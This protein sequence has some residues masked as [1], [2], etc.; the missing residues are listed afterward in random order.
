MSAVKGRLFWQFWSDKNFVLNTLFLLTLFYF[1]K[2]LLSAQSEQLLEL[3]AALSKDTLQLIWP[4]TPL[5]LL[6]PLLQS[7]P[8][9]LTMLFSVSLFESITSNLIFRKCNPVVEGCRLL[10]AYRWSARWRSY[11]KTGRHCQSSLWFW[12]WGRRW[13][14]KSK[15]V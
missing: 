15:L 7:T 13:G 8:K 1:Q 5:V 2:F 4:N 3:L 10:G 11:W 14:S 6:F 9:R 12:I